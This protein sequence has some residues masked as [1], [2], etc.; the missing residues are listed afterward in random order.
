MSINEITALENKVT[1]MQQYEAEAEAF[2]A[3]ADEIRDGIKAQMTDLGT[4]EIT[5][6]KYVIR[7]ISILTNRFDTKFFNDTA[8]TEIYTYYLKQ[9]SSK[10]FTISQ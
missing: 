6:P 4:D 2:K 8:T 9:V 10:R 3:K 7:F 5:T 1:L